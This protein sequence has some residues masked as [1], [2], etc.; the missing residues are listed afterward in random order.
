VSRAVRLA[1]GVKKQILLASCGDSIAY[2][3]LSRIRP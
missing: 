1:H 2:L 3:H